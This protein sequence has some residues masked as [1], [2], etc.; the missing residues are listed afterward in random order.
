L[1]MLYW[2][3]SVHA[4]AD[5][6]TALGAAQRGMAAGDDDFRRASMGGPPDS[7]VSSAGDS[8]ERAAEVLLSVAFAA[9]LHGMNCRWHAACAVLLVAY[10]FW[11]A[12]I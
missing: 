6:T 1:T 2:F 3:V 4:G 11:H 8:P 10:S 5:F 9:G 7:A 12:V